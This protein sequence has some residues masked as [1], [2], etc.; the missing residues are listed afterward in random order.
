MWWRKAC[1]NTDVYHFT[2]GTV[3]SVPLAQRDYTVALDGVEALV[4]KEGLNPQMKQC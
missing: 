2:Q 4:P 3:T 1:P